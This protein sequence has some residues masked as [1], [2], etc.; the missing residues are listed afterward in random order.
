M[1]QQRLGE[2]GSEC[3]P[4]VSLSPSSN[5]GTM[6]TILS[7]EQALAAEV[8]ILI[9]VPHNEPCTATLPNTMAPTSPGDCYRTKRTLSPVYPLRLVC[10]HFFL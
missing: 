2:G 3:F 6:G 4:W 9:H 8:P 7:T 10:Y 5:M 1:A